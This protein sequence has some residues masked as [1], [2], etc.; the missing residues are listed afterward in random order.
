MSLT[1]E[2]YQELLE[3]HGS[4]AAVARALGRDR[5]NLQRW[6]RRNMGA[7][8]REAPSV[9]PEEML[10][11]L[12]K[13]PRSVGELA[14]L[15]DKGPRTVNAWLEKLVKRGFNLVQEGAAWKLET[16]VAPAEVQVNMP[17]SGRL[18]F[19]AAGDS[20]L[21]SKYQQ[22]TYLNDFYDRCAARGVTTVYHPGDLLAGI[23]V[24]RGQ[25]NDIFRHTEDDQVQYAI[26]NYPRREGIQTVV[27]GG[28]HDLVF[29]KRGNSD[30]V[31]QIA[32]EREDITYLGPYSAWVQLTPLC[33]MYLLHPDGGTAYALSYKLQRLIA[34]FEGGR[35]PNILLAGHWHQYCNIFQRN[36]HGFLTPCFEAQ[37]D[38][39]R[40]RGLQPQ[41]GGLILEI[42]FSADGSIQEI[43]HELV[44]Y[45]KPKEHDY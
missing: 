2:K 34:S 32:T 23:D 9:N 27:I 40:R 18:V 36:V 17:A 4:L 41:I 6:V 14:D 37:T 30:P 29:V 19:G 26:E 38:F 45:L 5:R 31:R 42:E 28:N 10:L 33:S 25:V 15:V 44:A 7:A 24:Y 35:K 43:K 11:P 20:H 22:L 1:P 16:F 39:E 3:K 12:L 13:Q 21:C 8:L